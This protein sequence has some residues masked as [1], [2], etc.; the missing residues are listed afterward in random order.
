MPKQDRT[1]STVVTFLL[2]FGCCADVLAQAP[3]NRIAGPALRL[4]RI[5]HR[6]RFSA[7]IDG[8]V[9]LLPFLWAVG[10]WSAIISGV[11]GA[12]WG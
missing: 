12:V 10:W 4:A 8:S 3:A 1:S 2:I 5:S 6:H 11:R 9:A 7:G